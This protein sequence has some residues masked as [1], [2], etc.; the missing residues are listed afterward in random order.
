MYIYEF[1]NFLEAT[2]KN[3]KESFGPGQVVT[4]ETTAAILS[5]ANE[6][7]SDFEL[8]CLVEILREEY[9]GKAC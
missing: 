1:E 3:V 7:T 8:Q 6:C 9:W 4:S 2:K 5:A